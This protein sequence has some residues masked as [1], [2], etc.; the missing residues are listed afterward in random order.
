MR[1][2]F[3]VRGGTFRPLVG[4]IPRDGLGH[5]KHLHGQS[6]GTLE[7]VGESADAVPE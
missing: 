7:S 4:K 5:G 2:Y 3:C 1:Q 6:T